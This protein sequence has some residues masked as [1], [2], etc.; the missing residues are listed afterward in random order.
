[1]AR[2][3]GDGGSGRCERHAR[4]DR[5]RRCQSR[6]LRVTFAVGVLKGDQMNTV[7]RDA[8]ALGVAA[9]V[10]FLSAHTAVSDEATGRT[11][12]NGGR[13]SPWRPPCSAAA[14]SCPTCR[15]VTTFD[16]VMDAARPASRG[17]VRRARPRSALD[18]PPW[19]LS[20]RR[21]T[22]FVG[23]EGGWAPAELAAPQ[24]RARGSSASV[25][26]PCAPSW[27]RPWRSACCGR[28]GDGQVKA[29]PPS[30]HPPSPRRDRP[31]AAS[32]DRRHDG[33]RSSIWN[34]LAMRQAGGA[35]VETSTGAI[36]QSSAPV[37]LASVSSKA[38]CQPFG[39][40]C[41]VEDRESTWPRA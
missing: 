39:V 4:L 1:M 15:A 21:A 29:R 41:D 32:L 40:H 12:A 20:W 10:P 33:S 38:S 18:A 37:R 27:R 8:T 30:S 28:C 19:T 14:P 35:S 11:R 36:R 2:T 16:A 24:R 34:P 13:A 7:V 31:F 23:P 26:A 5:E 9:I 17:H 6:P 22:V 3:R 25:R